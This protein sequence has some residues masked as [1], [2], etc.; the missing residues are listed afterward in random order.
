VHGVPVRTVRRWLWW[1][2][3]GFAQSAFWSEAKAFFSAPVL[4]ERLPGS[5]L[6][7]F[8]DNAIDRTLNFISAITTTSVRTRFAVVM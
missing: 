1:W 4:V 6:E 8:A 5:L 3:N 2:Q 7:R